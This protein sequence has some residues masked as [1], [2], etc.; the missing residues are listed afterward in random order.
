MDTTPDTDTPT[1]APAADPAPAD[2]APTPDPPRGGS[3]RSRT[4]GAVAERLAAAHLTGLGMEVVE[5]NWSV[6]AGEVRGEIDIVA[7]DGD[8]LVVVEVKAR[9]GDDAGALE[10]VDGRKLARL[11]R[12]AAAWLDASDQRAEIV[13][14]D[15]VGVT[16]R[17]DGRPPVVDHIRDAR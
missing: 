1:E 11:R 9:R 7:R 12:L 15:V 14:I 8:A 2:A 13:R 17:L 6:A 3:P 10:A 5:R 4:L 16:W